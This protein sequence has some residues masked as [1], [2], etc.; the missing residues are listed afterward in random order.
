MKREPPEVQPP[1]ILDSLQRH[2]NTEDCEPRPIAE[3]TEI[4]IEHRLD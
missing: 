2:S 1:I 4:E 3:E